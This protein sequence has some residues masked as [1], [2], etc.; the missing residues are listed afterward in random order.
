MTPLRIWLLA[1]ITSIALV[2]VGVTL[3]IRTVHADVGLP[4]LTATVPP[5]VPAVPKAA[6]DSLT[7]TGTRPA[8]RKSLLKGIAS[9]YGE[10][11]DGRM[12]ASGESYDMYAMTACHPSLPFGSVVRVVNQNNGRSVLVRITDRSDLVRGRIID[13]SF[14]AAEQ[15]AMTRS[16]LARVSLEVLS[17]G[18]K[19]KEGQN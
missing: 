2:G 4:R 13:L 10:E 8:K 19:P 16:G 17:R 14:G 15:L 3:T 18:V 5:S 11:F 9:W 7:P 12:T 1:G 6:P